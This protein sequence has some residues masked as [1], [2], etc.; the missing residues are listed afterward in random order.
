MWVCYSVLESCWR[1]DF[2]LYDW[3]PPYHSSIDKGQWILIVQF[4]WNDRNWRNCQ[5]KDHKI[6]FVYTFSMS[7]T[8][9]FHVAYFWRS[10]E[11]CCELDCLSKM[12]ND[13]D[14]NMIGESRNSFV[15]FD[16]F[17][18][19]LTAP[20][21]FDLSP[22]LSLLCFLCGLFMFTFW[23]LQRQRHL[24]FIIC[25]TLVAAVKFTL[26]FFREFEKIDLV[27]IFKKTCAIVHIFES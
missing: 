11:M 23:M 19:S 16:S 18:D 15:I 17:V 2:I 10:Q 25:A 4:G 7:I 24:L 6:E 13:D 1:L 8:Y 20:N 21:N 26:S 9:Q 3:T 14:G 22:F 12:K 5:I 27:C